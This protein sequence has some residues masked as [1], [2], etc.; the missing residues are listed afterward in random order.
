MTALMC[1]LY[2]ATAATVWLNWQTTG[3]FEVDWE[4]YGSPDLLVLV[5][6]VIL[7]G[8]MSS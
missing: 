6:L 3:E 1:L 7:H 5:L 2:S 4:K 8:V